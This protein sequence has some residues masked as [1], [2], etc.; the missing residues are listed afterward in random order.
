[1][2]QTKV[3]PNICPTTGTLEIYNVQDEIVMNIICWF[4]SPRAK[5]PYN[6]KNAARFL[7]VGHSST[8]MRGPFEHK[9]WYCHNAGLGAI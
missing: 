3:L 7:T 4:H 6:G 5:R 9:K 1:M 8:Y 2:H